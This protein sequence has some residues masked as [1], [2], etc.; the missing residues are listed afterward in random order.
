LIDN[1]LLLLFEQF[2]QPP[3]ITDESLNLTADCIKPAGQPTS[4]A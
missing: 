1:V 2:N 3:L 4:C